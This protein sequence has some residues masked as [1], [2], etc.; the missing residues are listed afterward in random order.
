MFYTFKKIVTYF[1]SFLEYFVE[2]QLE[3]MAWKISCLFFWTKFDFTGGFTGLHFFNERNSTFKFLVIGSFLYWWILKWKLFNNIIY[4]I[5]N[6][7]HVS[8]FSICV[9]SI[10]VRECWKCIILTQRC[11]ILI[12]AFASLSSLGNFRCV[13]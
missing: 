5:I 9:T 6:F 3:F 7:Q 1:L 8:M 12:I 13:A 10:N 11:P 2:K 4:L